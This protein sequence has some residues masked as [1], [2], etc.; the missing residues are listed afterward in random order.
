MDIPVGKST[1]QQ[2]LSY[3]ASSYF[4]NELNIHN[5][6]VIN[7]L[8]Y[9]RKVYFIDTGFMTALSTKFS[10]N[11]GRLFENI[12]YYLLLRRN[13]MIY[14][15]KDKAGYEVDFVTL[16]SGRIKGLYQACYD[17]S[18]EETRRREVRALMKAGTSLNCKNLNLVT[19]V[20]PA[21]SNLPKEIK[22]I[23]AYEFFSTSSR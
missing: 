9:P 22:V 16:N 7:Q 3:I 10:Q 17:L 23:V 2:Y 11:K 19:L 1:V 5:A 4:M 12:I 20:K 6:S 13:E 8:N 14:Y 21:A 18:D 15:F